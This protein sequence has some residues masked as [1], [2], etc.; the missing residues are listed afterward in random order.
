LLDIEYAIPAALTKGKTRVTVRFQP[1]KDASTATVLEI[2]TIT[3][4]R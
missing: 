4:G 1:Q 3:G 2:R